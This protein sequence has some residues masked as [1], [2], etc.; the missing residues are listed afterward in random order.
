MIFLNRNTTESVCANADKAQPE[1]SSAGVPTRAKNPFVWLLRFFQG[2]VIGTGAI[3]PG[4]SGG[5]LSIVFGIYEPLMA[6]L[7]SPGKDLLKNLR[8]FLPYVLGMAAGVVAL[9]GL[10]SYLFGVAAA[11]VTVFFIGCI[12]GTLP[13]L[14]KTASKHGRRPAHTSALVISIFVTLALMLL[15]D[16]FGGE[17]TAVARF[18][19]L[20][21]LELPAKADGG[22]L[23]AQSITVRPLFGS[24]TTDFSLLPWLSSCVL[25]IV[26]GAIVAAGAIVPG[27][28]PSS[29]LIYVGLYAKMT[30]A[31]AC[32]DASILLPLGIGMVLCLLLFSRLV[33][34]LFRRAHGTMYNIVIG[35]VIASTI[36]I[37][38][39]D[40]GSLGG[41][42]LSAVCFAAGLALA[43]LLAR[44]QTKVDYRED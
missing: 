21:G 23:L 24:F 18:A 27:L 37:I 15:L 19:G 2:M 35:V 10:V 31:F 42:V 22:S 40:Y 7:A 14:F 28:S 13:A 25:W 1:T 16:W 32:L 6:F 30:E 41:I 12:I 17:G 4:I 29:I 38:P 5:V 36:M 33:H 44:L 11:T 34:Y 8:F 3:L 39:F 26:C 43:L 9:S 20:L